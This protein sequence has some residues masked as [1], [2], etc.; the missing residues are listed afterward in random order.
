MMRIRPWAPL[1]VFGAALTIALGGCAPSDPSSISIATTSP[2]TVSTPE[3]SAAPTPDVA[4][5]PPSQ[6]PCSTP[7]PTAPA[8]TAEAIENYKAVIQTGNTQPMAGTSC[9]TITLI[10][11]GSGCCGPTQRD[12]ALVQ[13]GQWLNPTTASWNFNIDPATLADWRTKIYGQYVP[14]GSLIGIDEVNGKVTSVIFHGNVVTGLF[15]ANTI[16]MTY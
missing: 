11:A 6:F 4:P 12:S 15:I 10:L 16:E 2:T 8:P 7:A 1:M 9:E 3:E 14:E 5:I 13:W